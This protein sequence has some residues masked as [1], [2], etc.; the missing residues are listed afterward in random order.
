VLPAWGKA[1]GFVVGVLA[2]A[3]IQIALVGHS[4]L[5]Q[6]QRG[7]VDGRLGIEGNGGM[8]DAG[9]VDARGRGLAVAGGVMV[10]GCRQGGLPGFAI[11][12]EVA[13]AVQVGGTEPGQVVLVDVDTVV[14]IG[15]AGG[16][17][18]VED[19]LGGGDGAG[20]GFGAGDVQQRIGVILKGL[21]QQ[22]LGGEGAHRHGAGETGG[23]G[24]RGG[25]R[26]CRRH[27]SAQTERR[28]QAR[29]ETAAADRGN[30]P[31]QL[32]DIDRQKKLFCRRHC[33]PEVGAKRAG[34]GR[35]RACPID[36]FR[37]PGLLRPAAGHPPRCARGCRRGPRNDVE[38]LVGESKG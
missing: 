18:G 20:D 7:Q 22:G 27:L 9:D 37:R 33:Q 8:A 12:G 36:N 23:R 28:H 21:L 30:R 31:I 16:Q 3:V 26:Q 6:I 35:G 10:Q 2:G 32:G 14:E 15:M 17:V 19:Q 11:G 38:T 25:L 29:G 24:R 5:G 4:Q 1:D 13:L 34:G